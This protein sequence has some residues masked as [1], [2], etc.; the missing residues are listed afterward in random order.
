MP[1]PPISAA[2]ALERLV[3]GNHRFLR[4]EAR[5]ATFCPETL[6]K[7]AAGQRPFATILG[8]S[9]SRVAP[10]IVFDAGL[11][12][13]FIIR[14]A[15][16]VVS[17]EIMGSLQYA[18]LHLETPLFVVLG[19]EGCGAVHAALDQLHHGTEHPARIAGLLDG[20][21]PGL[22]GVDASLPP[23][24]QVRC[25]VEANVHW[26]MQQLRATPEARKLALEGRLKLVGAVYEIATGAVRWLE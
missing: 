18:E 8:C 15:G 22:A 4:G 2:E 21:V 5:N 7:L 13:L 12:E 23:G 1:T 17:Q 10:E 6:A 3:E 24:E 11:G 26:S 25:A 14:V 20:I 19:H 9:D 16:N